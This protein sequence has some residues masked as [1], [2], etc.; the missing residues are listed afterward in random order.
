VF[1]FSFFINENYDQDYQTMDAQLE[2]RFPL[3]RL[4]VQGLWFFY[5]V[6]FL[7]LHFPLISP[8]TI[9]SYVCSLAD[10]DEF[11]GCAADITPMPSN[12]RQGDCY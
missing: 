10:D 4:Y 2:H 5:H 6:S 9:K 11:T 1:L 8:L 3:G 12:G 7:L